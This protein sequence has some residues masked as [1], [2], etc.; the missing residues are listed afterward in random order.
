MSDTANTIKFVPQEIAYRLP[1]KEW[2]RTVKK[3]SFAFNRTIA[4]LQEAGAEIQTRN[5]DVR[6]DRAIKS[7]RTGHTA[8]VDK[9]LALRPNWDRAALLAV[10]KG[11]G[12]LED[13][14]LYNI[15]DTVEEADA[16]ER[17]F[18]SYVGSTVEVDK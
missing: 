8:V 3:T 14:G 1:G 11:F 16:L 7:V 18:K 13:P 4:Q 9:I 17:T 15:L 12:T 6:L 10:G 2:K 5:A